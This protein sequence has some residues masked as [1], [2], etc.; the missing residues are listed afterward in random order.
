MPAQIRWNPG[1][2]AGERTLPCVAEDTGRF[3]QVKPMPS[4][5]GEAA[6][7]VGDGKGYRWRHRT[8]YMASMTF[9]VAYSDEAL[10]Q[11][12]LEWANN[13]GEFSIDT[14]DIESNTYDELQVAPGTEVDCSPPDP[15][16]LDFTLTFTALNIAVSPVSIRFQYE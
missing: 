9:L 8:D 14:G 6:I 16:T 7:A 2:S 13:F 11:E 3:N 12:F 10:V 15:E 4:P 5:I 1:D